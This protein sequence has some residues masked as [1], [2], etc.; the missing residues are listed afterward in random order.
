MSSPSKPDESIHTKQTEF[1]STSSIAS[2]TSGLSVLSDS[3]Y[4]DSNIESES[5]SLSDSLSDFDTDDESSGVIEPPPRSPMSRI[6]VNPTRLVTT[7]FTATSGDEA[8]TG[9]QRTNAFHGFTAKDGLQY[10]TYPTHQSSRYQ[11]PIPSYRGYMLTNPMGFESNEI[12]V[13]EGWTF[14]FMNFEAG[15]EKGFRCARSV[16][17]L[18]DWSRGLVDER[19]FE[20]YFGCGVFSADRL[21]HANS[22]SV[23]REM[24]KSAI[25]EWIDGPFSHT[26]VCPTDFGA[27]CDPVVY[28]KEG[29]YHNEKAKAIVKRQRCNIGYY[30]LEG[31]L[32]TDSEKEDYEDDLAILKERYAEYPRRAAE[33]MVDIQRAIELRRRSQEKR[34]EESVNEP[35]INLAKKRVRADPN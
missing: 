9:L 23:I 2:E 12:H 25:L 10:F 3:S 16:S 4:S 30:A 21:H 22:V 15:F 35:I 27:Q 1:I 26:P 14:H 28:L 5:D 29:R 34:A 33:A 17:D 7:E 31:T 13:V 24:P 20:V 19:V 32:Y 18:F 11:H 6:S 8:W